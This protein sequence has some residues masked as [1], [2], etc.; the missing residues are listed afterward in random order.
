M[1]TIFTPSF[2]DEANTNAQ[3]LTV[4][5]VVS[6]L[7]ADRFRVIMLGDGPADP[8]ILARENTEILRW[9]RHGNTPRWLSHVLFSKID[10]YF[11]PREGPLD[12]LFMF[13]R[14][15]LR[16]RIAL[17]TYVVVA[18]DGG[19]SPRLARSIREA[20]FVAGNSG[21]VSQTVEHRFGSETETIHSGIKHEFFYPTPEARRPKTSLTVLYAGSFQARKRLNVVIGEAAKRPALEFRLGG[22]G[23]RGGG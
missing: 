3:N 23:E 20:D 9:S 8:R 12:T 21:F 2:A 5:E 11:F 14:R 16:L 6:R 22:K 17:V 19:L 7:P 10:V 4:K 15:S 1:L 13:F 18:V